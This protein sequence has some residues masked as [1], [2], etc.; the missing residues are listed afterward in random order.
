MKTIGTVDRAGAV[1]GLFTLE[2]PEWGTTELARRLSISKSQAYEM[3]TSL[4]TIGLLQ[5]TPG[6]RYRLGWRTVRLGSVALQSE[7]LV[8]AAAPWLRRLVTLLPELSAHMAVWDND[9]AMF[10]SQAIGRNAGTKISTLSRTGKEAP[11]HCTSLGKVLAAMRT[12]EELSL[13]LS[14]TRLERYTRETLT[15]PSRLRSELAVIRERGFATDHREFEREMS[16]IAAP[17]TQD[18]DRVIAAIGVCVPPR[19]WSRNGEMYLRS[20]TAT[21]R[22]ISAKLERS[23]IPR[24]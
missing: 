10:V 22:R 12:S 23:E 5:K 21:S 2:T 11:L 1:L 3:L 14:A 8:S 6:A 15:R 16:C 9:R 13:C 24:S 4:T 7:G 19:A 20:V 18:G 17:V